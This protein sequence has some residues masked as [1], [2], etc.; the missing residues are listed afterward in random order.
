MI[1]LLMM[2]ETATADLPSNAFLTSDR[3]YAACQI[4]RPKCDAYIEGAID[5]LLASLTVFQTHA[6]QICVPPDLTVGRARDIVIG[7]LAAD[8]DNQTT[9]AASSI[10]VA[11]LPILKCKR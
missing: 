9:S 2:A 10:A 7:F 3:L 1:G 8:P 4:D 6:I 11:L 5:G